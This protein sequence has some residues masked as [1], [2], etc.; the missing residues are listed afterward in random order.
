MDEIIAEIKAM[1]LI[2]DE[3]LEDNDRLDL[4]VKST[5]NKF[6]S[7]TNRRHLEDA[8]E[9][10]PQ[11]ARTSIAEACLT[12]LEGGKEI[13]SMSDNGQS[14]TFSTSTLGDVEEMWRP[15]RLAKISSGIYEGYK[16]ED[17]L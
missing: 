9:A 7:S 13:S 11:E 3:E 8:D 15:Y 6:L 2:L 10:V 12:G 4:I 14:V 16:G 17:E 5:V 1:V